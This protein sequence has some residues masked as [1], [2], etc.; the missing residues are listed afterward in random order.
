[1]VFKDTYD[2][3][4]ADFTKVFRVI[5]GQTMFSKIILKAKPVPKPFNS[6]ED[7]KVQLGDNDDDSAFAEMEIPNDAMLKDDG[8]I[9]SGQAN[10]RLDVMDPRNMSDIL[11]APGDFTTV[12]EDGEEQMLVSY[13]E[14][15]I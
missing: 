13:T 2:R 11:T 6:S 7:F 9:F 10:L 5:K 4:Y 1:M 12:D 8:T 15:L 3:E 14:C